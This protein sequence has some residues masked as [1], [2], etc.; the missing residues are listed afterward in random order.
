MKAEI[1]RGEMSISD[2]CSRRGKDR[3]RISVCW[4]KAQPCK[5]SEI[6]IYI[7]M[8][9]KSVKIMYDSES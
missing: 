5:Q 8:Y 6:Y 3:I 2:L 4:S 9:I 1:Q 7:H